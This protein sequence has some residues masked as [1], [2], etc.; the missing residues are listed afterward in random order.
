MAVG[1]KIYLGLFMDVD[2]NQ[3]KAVM[4][5]GLNRHN[6]TFNVSAKALTKDDNY[7]YFTN[8]T[9]LYKAHKNT[10][11]I[12]QSYSPIQN[13]SPIASD[14][15]FI[16]VVG[17]TIANTV[18]VIE[19]ETMTKINTSGAYGGV[20]NVLGV[21]ET[22]I[23]IG[24]KANSLDKLLKNDLSTVNATAWIGYEII[25]LGLDAD[26]LYVG[27]LNNNKINKIKKSDMK[28]VAEYSGVSSTMPLVT[29]EGF[30]YVPHSTSIT[31]VNAETMAK[32]TTISV[33]S[34]V[35][36]TGFDVSGDNLYYIDSASKKIYVHDKSTLL[37]KAVS[38]TIQTGVT[39]RL[40]A[41]NDS[42]YCGL[43]NPDTTVNYGIS[44]GISGYKKAVYL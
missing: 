7:L 18:E 6:E 12:E 5:E 27:R 13:D 3:Y 25:T 2:N 40:I 37:Q 11:K 39:G 19:K 31:K 17:T 29:D 36:I 42:V 34:G 44:Y 21:D 10:M 30:L 35:S 33:P 26:F 4:K 23:Y 22:N 43:L 24:G 41:D 28:A 20:I 1:D 14:E 16:Y 32:I 38:D 15:G 8:G 9:T